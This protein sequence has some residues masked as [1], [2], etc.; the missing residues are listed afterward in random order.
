MTFEKD[1]INKRHTCIVSVLRRVV[2][3]IVS[4]GRFSGEA[5]F[6]TG[7][8]KFSRKSQIVNI[9]SFVGYIDFVIAN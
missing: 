2:R 5:E 4:V 1:L 3:G 8:G 9:F 7:V 6:G